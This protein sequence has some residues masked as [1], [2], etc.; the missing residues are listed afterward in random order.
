MFAELGLSFQPVEEFFST[1]RKG[2]VR[3]MHFQLPPCHHDKLAYCVRGR[4]LDV[5][6]DLRCALPTYGRAAS[7]ELSLRNHHQ[8]F[9]PHGGAHG[10]ARDREVWWWLPTCFNGGVGGRV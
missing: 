1:S 9:I 3:G 10:L 4:V 7:V 5:L 8:V 6:L 2:V